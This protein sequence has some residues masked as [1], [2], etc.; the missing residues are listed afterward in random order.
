MVAYSGPRYR[1]VVPPVGVG[2]VA[3]SVLGEG[4]LLVGV[5]SGGEDGCCRGCVRDDVVEEL[6]GSLV[7]CT[8]AAGYIPAPTKTGSVPPSG[9]V[10]SL[11]VEDEQPRPL[12]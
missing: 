9:S 11:S 8:G 4:A 7:T 1:L 6:S 12:G 5:I 10:S 3:V 2:V